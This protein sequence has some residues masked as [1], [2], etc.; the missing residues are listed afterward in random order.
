MTDQQIVNSQGVE[1]AFNGSY[2]RELSV[3]MVKLESI[4]SSRDREVYKQN[5]DLI[6]KEL[7]TLQS[8]ISESKNHCLN[9]EHFLKLLENFIQSSANSQS[10][11]EKLLLE[12]PSLKGK[13][14]EVIQQSVLFHA[15]CFS[16]AKELMELLPQALR[17]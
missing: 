5:I 6:Q 12:A 10:T 13:E 15:A 1:K 7:D 2:L 16:L 17:T 9:R 14:L 4:F 11:I 8:Y 3:E